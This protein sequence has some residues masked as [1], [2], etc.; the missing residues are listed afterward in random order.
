MG[1]GILCPGQGGQNRDMLDI[2]SGD[3]AALAVFDRAG[4]DDPRRVLTSDAADLTRN[5]V[6]QPLLC[7]VQAAAW[8][9]LSPLLPA[10]MA[11]AGYSIGELAAYHIAG[12]LS[13]DT[14]LD[15]ASARAAAMDAAM[16]QLG[17][18]GSMLA[19]RGLDRSTLLSFGVEIAIA[20]GP[21]RFVIGGPEGL[22]ASVRRRLE[23]AGATLTDIPVTVAS[24][25][26]LMRRALDPFRA[27]L[28]AASFATPRCPVL[29][30]IDGS[31]I[32]SANQA[33]TVLVAQ[34]AQTV[35]W[36]SCLDGMVERGCTVLLELG[37]G[38]ALSR[39]TSSRFPALPA[40]SLSEFRTLRGAVSWVERQLG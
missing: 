28:K 39:M 3:T 38:D 22:I 24:H 35:E 23:A 11:V 27:A 15:C 20:N 40:R 29:A 32:F 5:S 4:P 37:P 17:V 14:L 8:A 12:S 1:L 16:V 18:A 33:R 2:L 10:P 34:L 31:A 19:V 7:A 25:T 6:A 26:S 9:A 13:L 30:G 36:A 21:D